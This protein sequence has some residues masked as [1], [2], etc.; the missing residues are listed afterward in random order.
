M[1]DINNLLPLESRFQTTEP[2]SYQC[3]SCK[4]A[5]LGSRFRKMLLTFF[6]LLIIP[7]CQSMPSEISVTYIQHQNIQVINGSHNA[8][9]QVSCLD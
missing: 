2:V 1:R 3:V 8:S 7:T 9:K 6:T 4:R 5:Q